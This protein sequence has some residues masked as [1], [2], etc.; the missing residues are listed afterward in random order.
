VRLY[1]AR[2]RL[3]AHLTDEPEGNHPPH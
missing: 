1:R 2:Q 3:R